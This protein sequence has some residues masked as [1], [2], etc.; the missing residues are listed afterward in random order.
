MPKSKPPRKNR[1]RPKLTN[2]P[3]EPIWSIV[4]EKEGFDKLRTD[5]EFALILNLARAT[6]SLSFCYEAVIYVDKKDSFNTHR[7]LYHGMS[8]A[9]AVLYE[10]L[11]CA[12]KLEEYF[13]DF[14]SY[15][16]GFELLLKDPIVEEMMK[17]KTRFDQLRNRV[18]YHFNEDIIER[19]L[20]WI[21]FD[22]YVF[23]RGKGETYRHQH[24]TLAEDIA[25]NFI[26]GEEKDPVK[27][28]QIYKEMWDQI[29]YVM[30]RFFSASQKLIAEVL[31]KKG[32]KV[33]VEEKDNTVIHYS[34]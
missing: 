29:I 8:F 16:D 5:L 9:A 20:P 30:T 31:L 32:W 11:K 13:F 22:S 24:Y 7:Q 19:V 2:K 3:D 21:E 6:N 18:T 10:G 15:K 14:D 26:I 25:L 28:Q 27:G 12:K 1:K 33:K 4:I 34:Q 17:P 23:G